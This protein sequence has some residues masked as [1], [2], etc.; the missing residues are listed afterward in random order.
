[1]KL[2]KNDLWLNVNYTRYNMGSFIIKPRVSPLLQFF[3]EDL[4][5]HK[6]LVLL[7]Y[8]ILCP[9]YG[10]LQFCLHLDVKLPC[11]IG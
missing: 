1:M 9:L 3:P 2:K 7:A 10:Y 5:F 6:I 11:V 4:L 8:R